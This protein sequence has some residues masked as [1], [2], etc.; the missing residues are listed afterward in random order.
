MKGF[1]EYDIY[2]I[3]DKPIEYKD[4]QIYPVTMDKYLEFHFYVNCLLLDKNSI[5]DPT[6][7]SMTYLDFLYYMSSTTELPYLYMFKE[8]LKMV[9]HIDKDDAFYFGLLE[10]GKAIFKING[11]TYN[12]DD[13]N[14]IADIIM[15]QNEIEHIDDTIQKEVREEME[16]AE[17][18]KMKQNA[19]KMCSLEDQMICVLISTSL[20]LEDIYELTIRKFTKILARVD[21]KLHYEIYLGAQ[22]SG[23]VKFDDNNQIKHWMADLT[24]QD[25]YSDVKVDAEAMHHKIDSANN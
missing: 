3:Y 16:R 17:A 22:M 1:S 13:F 12:S 10:N 9:L 24:R 23:L 15:L 18:Y 4:L 20:K 14:K 7:I 19:Y 2:L 11:V 8:L 21:H 25:K 6:V 5:P